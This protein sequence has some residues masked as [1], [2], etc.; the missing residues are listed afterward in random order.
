MRVEESQARSAIN[1]GAERAF[2]SDYMLLKKAHDRRFWFSDFNDMPGMMYIRK[3]IVLFGVA[4]S[5]YN[6]IEAMVLTYRR[7]IYNS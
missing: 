2:D 5:A 3:Y 7:A 1:Y 6:R 4:A